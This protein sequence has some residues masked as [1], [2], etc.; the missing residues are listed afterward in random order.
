M[1]VLI[2]LAVI[3]LLAAVTTIGMV[4]A[5]IRREEKHH[6]LTGEA[7]G[8]LAHA[9][10]RLN[11]VY[12]RTPSP[13]SPTIDTRQLPSPLA[14]PVDHGRTLARA[15]RSRRASAFTPP[16]RCAASSHQ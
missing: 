10:R 14:G 11:G 7:P 16:S 13:P 6:T 1:T 12:V 3:G 8:P 15:R 2:A 4:S 9:G 5:A